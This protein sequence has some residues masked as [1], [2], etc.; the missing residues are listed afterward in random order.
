MSVGVAAGGSGTVRGVRSSGRQQ[1]VGKIRPVE[2]QMV[3]E[4]VEKRGWSL[5]VFETWVVSL[6][7]VHRSVDKLSAGVWDESLMG[8]SDGEKLDHGG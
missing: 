3:F 1:L 5:L 8:V 4:V 2:E 7:C 6:T